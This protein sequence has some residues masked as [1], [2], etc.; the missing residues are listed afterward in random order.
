VSTSAFTL[1]LFRANIPYADHILNGVVIVSVLSAG[2]SAMYAS[3]RT[4]MSLAER[5]SAPKVFLITYNGVPL[6]AMGVSFSVAF[7]TLLMSSLGAE[8][9]FTWMVSLT[10]LSTLISWYVIDLHRA[11]ICMVHLRFRAALEEQG[12]E[13][14]QLPYTAPFYPYGDIIA[15]SGAFI[16]LIGSGVILIVEGEPFEE[17]LK[18]YLGLPLF[19]ILFFWYKIRHGTKVVALDQCDFASETDG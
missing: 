8:T 7:L 13:I 19:P 2:N 10:G 6:N 9:L 12:F 11:T 16:V 5:G 18:L 14:S 3:S 17:F 4:L 1:A 15:L